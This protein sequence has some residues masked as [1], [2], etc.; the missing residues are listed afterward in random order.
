MEIVFRIFV[1][2]YFL[3]FGL[4]SVFG[5]IKIPEP[6]DELK[7]ILMALSEAKVIMPLVKFVE[8]GAGF[9]LLL[10]IFVSLSI[11]ALAPIVI[12]IVLLQF[13]LNRKRSGFVLL[14]VLVPYIALV[15]LHRE[16]FRFLFQI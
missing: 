15:V 14:Q 12:G 7:K 8:I 1:G 4:N 5:W 16:S 2:G 9:C 13:F 3:F 11:L 10:G 6:A